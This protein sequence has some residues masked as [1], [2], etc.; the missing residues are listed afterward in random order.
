MK[1][2]QIGK[3]ENPNRAFWANPDSWPKGNKAHIFL[4]AAFNEVGSA[5]FGRKWT[6]QEALAK[7][8]YSPS[9][10]E[11]ISAPP[12]KPNLE[13]WRRLIPSRANTTQEQLD[14]MWEKFDDRIGDFDKFGIAA[15]G[16]TCLG[17]EYN[18]SRSPI[19][20]SDT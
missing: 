7:F 9:D 5:M 20:S 17:P 19:D 2:L 15:H 16:R 11:R 10:L 13:A 18:D 6:E 14:Q 3:K 1:S 12:S 8:D 4:A